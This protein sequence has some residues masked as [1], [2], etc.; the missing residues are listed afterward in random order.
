MWLYHCICR[1]YFATKVSFLMVHTPC[2][3]DTHAHKV[4]R[5]SFLTASACRLKYINVLTCLEWKWN[6]FFLT[7]ST[8]NVVESGMCVFWPFQPP[9]SSNLPARHWS[10]KKTGVVVPDAVSVSWRLAFRSLSTLDMFVWTLTLAYF[11]ILAGDWDAFHKFMFAHKI[12]PELATSKKHCSRLYLQ[13]LSDSLSTCIL[14]AMHAP[15]SLIWSRCLFCLQ[16]FKAC[17][18]TVGMEGWRTGW[19]DGWV[20]YL[21]SCTTLTTATNTT[22]STATTTA[23]TALH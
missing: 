5:V 18:R 21:T 14:S 16:M 22:T 12:C 13:M 17:S 2:C 11:L 8:L 7:V 20:T 1:M 23:A 9:A 6:V 4:L 10:S 19:M 3:F 15:T